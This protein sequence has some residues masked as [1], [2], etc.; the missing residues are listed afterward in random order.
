ML[1]HSVLATNNLNSSEYKFSLLFILFLKV[2]KW[3][4]STDF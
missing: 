2:Q 1:D 4:I 3:K